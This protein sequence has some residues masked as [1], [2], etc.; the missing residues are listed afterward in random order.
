MSSVAAQLET[1]SAPATRVLEDRGIYHFEGRIRCPLAGIGSRPDFHSN[2]LA[3]DSDDTRVIIDRDGGRITVYNPHHYDQKTIVADL[4]FLA[5][6][7][8]RSGKATAFEL[9][10]K[11]FKKGDR[12]STDFHRH[13]RTQESLV[14]ADFEPFEVVATDGEQDLVLTDEDTSRKLCVGP[15][16]GLL[17]IKSMMAMR[18]NLDGVNQDPSQPGYRLAD[19]SMG[20]GPNRFAWMMVRAKLESLR[21]DCSEL[22]RA[23]STGA[24]SIPDMLYEGAWQLSLTVYTTFMMPEVVK[25]DLFLF[26]LD[27]HPLL[28]DVR[29]RGLEKG[30]TLAFRF[31]QGTGE[32][33]V[34]GHFEELPDAMEIA[35]A[36]LEFHMLGGLL[37]EHT[38][39]RIEA[40]AVG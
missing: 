17:L 11:V 32:V 21:D 22:V 30:Q 28:A 38:E 5:E 26:G 35:R 20:F 4:T 40:S 9:H 27:D 2:R 8:T 33:G 13:M 29:E 6:G 12:F 7:R 24:A 37:L 14:S 39:R 3:L 25:R 31:E 23:A 15:S 10:L 1:D 34:D 36:Y 18:D 16:L 19:L